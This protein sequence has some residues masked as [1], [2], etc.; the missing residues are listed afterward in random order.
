MYSQGVAMEEDESAVKGESI[1]RKFG[2][3]IFFCGLFF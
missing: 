1:Y 3:F 2:S